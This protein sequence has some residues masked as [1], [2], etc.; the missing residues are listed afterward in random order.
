MTIF[1]KINHMF[2]PGNGI[3]FTKYDFL[4]FHSL[5]NF[6]SSFML[7]CLLLFYCLR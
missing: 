6:L 1:V 4:K 3:R 5:V 2:I 7:L